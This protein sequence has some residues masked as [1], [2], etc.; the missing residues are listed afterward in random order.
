[1]PSTHRRHVPWYL[2]GLRR[3]T[4]MRAAATRWPPPCRIFACSITDDPQVGPP[5]RNQSDSARPVPVSLRDDCLATV[6]ADDV[7]GDPTDAGRAEHA[8][9]PCHVLRRRHAATR[10]PRLCPLQ[11]LVGTGDL[12]LR[13]G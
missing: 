4:R 13:R 6:D 11:H 9:R 1:Y 7:P 2:A 5:A 3:A 12:R 10:V 8:D